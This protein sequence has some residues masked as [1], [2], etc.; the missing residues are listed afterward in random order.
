MTC[1]S[2]WSARMP[3]STSCRMW[4][5]PAAGAS[6]ACKACACGAAKRCASARSA[7]RTSSMSR[8]RAASI[9]RRCWAASRPISAPASAAGKAARSRVG[10]RLPL[11]QAAPASATKFRLDGSWSSRRRAFARSWAAGRSSSRTARS[12]PSSPAITRSGRAPTAWACV[13]PV[14]DPRICRGFDITS[15]AVAPGSIQMPG[16]G[17]PIVLLAD[18]QTTGGYPKIA[19]VIS[20][21]LPALGRLPVGAKIGVRSCRRIEPPKRRAASMV[22]AGRDRVSI[23]PLAA[24]ARTWRRACSNAISSAAS[25]TPPPDDLPMTCRVLTPSCHG[26]PSIARQRLVGW[27][28]RSP[29]IAEPTRRPSP[30][31]PTM[32][33]SASSS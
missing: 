13:L 17:Q 15:D 9:S 30:S 5:R 32:S 29:A 12:R 18:R 20:A 19:T 4:R 27:R 3:P 31:R 1:G 6:R 14:A 7:A 21:D 10:D 23:V 11:R 28:D 33:R 16:N 22:A 25:S 8:S 26:V 2:R 24:P